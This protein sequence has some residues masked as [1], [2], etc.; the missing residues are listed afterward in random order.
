MT[1]SS[2]LSCTLITFLFLFAAGE[3]TCGVGGRSCGVAVGVGGVSNFDNVSPFK[4]YANIDAKL[5]IALFYY[6]ESSLYEQYREE[7]DEAKNFLNEHFKDVYVCSVD[8]TKEKKTSSKFQVSSP[9]ELRVFLPSY[10]KLKVVVD[11]G[12]LRD[13]ANREGRGPHKIG[14]SLISFVQ[15]LQSDMSATHEE[16]NDILGRFAD[17]MDDKGEA[18]KILKEFEAMTAAISPRFESTKQLYVSLLTNIVRKGSSFL[19]ADYNKHHNVLKS[20]KCHDENDC[21]IHFRHVSLLKVFLERVM[22]KDHFG[23]AAGA[24]DDDVVDSIRSRYQLLPNRKMASIKTTAELYDLVSGLRARKS[25][26]DTLEAAVQEETVQSMIKSKHIS[27]SK[28]LDRLMAEKGKAMKIKMSAIHRDVREPYG[29]TLLKCLAIQDALADAEAALARLE[30]ALLYGGA[31]GA[32][33]DAKVHETTA[34]SM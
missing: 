33:V 28:A 4:L 7:F 17:A 29:G 30:N 1:H 12:L 10:D 25:E 32:K 27:R 13:I 19:T 2:L 15:N 3:K 8:A 9:F 5:T 22:G 14:K 31:V 6:P 23:E 34:P 24:Q 26:C 16:W 18:G 21:M 11:I 20:S